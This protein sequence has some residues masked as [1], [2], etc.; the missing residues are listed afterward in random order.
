M[1]N[2]NYKIVIYPDRTISGQHP[3]RYNASFVNKIAALVT[4]LESGTRD[5]ILHARDNQLKRVPETHEHYDALQYPLIFWEELEGYHFEDFLIDPKSK[6]P[7]GKKVS[8]KDFYS[9][10]IMAWS[11]SFHI[12]LRFRHLSH[13][14]ITDMIVK[15]KSEQLRYI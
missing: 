10:H 12:L 13:Q 5:I 8:C 15:M 4:G 2:E 14:S 11:D 7:R 1:P 3:Q 9:Y 6:K